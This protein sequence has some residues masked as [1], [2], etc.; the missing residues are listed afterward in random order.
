M[1]DITQMAS[2]TTIEFS[3]EAYRNFIKA[4][5]NSPYTRETYKNSLSLYL[6]YRGFNTCEQLLQED[7]KI[8]QAH[9][10]DYVNYMKDES[11]LSKYTINNRLAAV[12][13]FYEKNQIELKW[14]FIKD[15]IGKGGKKKNTNGRGRG[16]DRPYSKLEIAKMLEAAD[17]RGK[18]AVLLM[19]TAGL[20][21]GA[22]TSLNV[23]DLEKVEKYNLYKLN[24]YSDDEDAYYISYCT[25][26][27]SALI[28]FYLEYR[29]LHGERPVED[30]APLIRELF[31]ID[32]EIRAAKPKRIDTQAFRKMIR[33]I[34]LK[35]GVIERQPVLD[36]RGE[37]R[38][39]KCT[40]GLRKAFQTTAINAGMSPLYSEI[41]MGH[42]S[43]GLA[44]ESYV[45]PTDEDL[46]EGND[47]MRG[48]IGIIDQLTISDEHRLKEKVEKLQIEVSK[49]DGILAD[50]A[51]M[52]QQLGLE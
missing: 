17:L 16:R 49:V 8:A 3:G 32:D 19:F 30:D 26:E 34:G 25:P 41:L 44:L 39:V 51:Q 4:L 13:K 52:R 47:R 37:R 45:K 28:D 12:K 23:G 46:L 10:V 27:C 22:I 29:H 7:E 9:L 14:R 18:I 35:A 2:T 33:I 21:V 15:Y 5:D 20:R 40:H 11:Q 31:D 50:L 1:N 24:V 6:R 43:G 42:T 48:Y 38:A 36:G